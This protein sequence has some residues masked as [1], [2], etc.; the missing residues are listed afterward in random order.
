MAQDCSSRAA[1]GFTGPKYRL[2]RTGQLCCILKPAQFTA[3]CK[4]AMKTALLWQPSL[5]AAREHKEEAASH[6]PHAH[7]GGRLGTAV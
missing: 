2:L 5:S 3:K 4:A 1:P 6:L 7:S